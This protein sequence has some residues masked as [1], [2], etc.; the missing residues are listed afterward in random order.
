[1]CNE[2]IIKKYFLKKSDKLNHQFLIKFFLENDKKEKESN[3]IY[4]YKHALFD[5]LGKLN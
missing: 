4:M 3:R 2:S 1:M 5:S